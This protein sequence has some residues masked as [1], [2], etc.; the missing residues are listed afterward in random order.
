MFHATKTLAT[1]SIL[2]VG[3]GGATAV[4]ADSPNVAPQP[5]LTAGHASPIRIPGTKVRKGTM[6]RKGQAIAW[7][8]VR[9]DNAKTVRFRLTCPGTKVLSGIANGEGGRAGF[10]LDQHAPYDGKH[11]VK[12]RADASDKT[13]PVVHGTAYGLCHS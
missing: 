2:A 5:A 6:L 10:N 12:L 11:S 1:I 13:L 8:K 4:A 9:V 3:A 7:T